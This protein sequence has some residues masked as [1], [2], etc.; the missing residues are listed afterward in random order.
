MTTPHDQLK[1]AAEA[2]VAPYSHLGPT[3]LMRLKGDISTNPTLLAMVEKI[4]QLQAQLKEASTSH[5]KTL[6][7]CEKTI[8]EL[9]AEVELLKKIRNPNGTAATIQE[10]QARVAELEKLIDK[11]QS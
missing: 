4:E 2:I 3:F 11:Q 1:Q 5:G 7:M 6:L 9:Q 8:S 10:L